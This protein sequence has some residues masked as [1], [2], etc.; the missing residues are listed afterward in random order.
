MELEARQLHGQS[1]QAREAGD[2]TKSLELS[3]RAMVSYQKENDLLGFA[4]AL[5][6]RVI[7]LR[8]LYEQTEN[9]AYLILAKYTAMASVD[10]AQESGDKTALAIPLFNL[11]KLQEI[12]GEHQNATNSFREALDNIINNPPVVHR[13]P[14]RPAII[15]DF[16]FHLAHAEYNTGDKTALERAESALSELETSAEISDYNKNVWVSGNHMH[17]VEML[18]ED[19]PEKAKEHLQ[20][21]KEIIDSDERLKLRKAQWEKLAATFK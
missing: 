15:A 2:F 17:L 18:R 21:A 5:A 20:K 12:L 10:I 3:E 9:K 13:V 6:G 8:H 4:E 11:G 7:T 1:E 16:K 14:E 19:N